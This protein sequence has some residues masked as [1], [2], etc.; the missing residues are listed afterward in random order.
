M[1]RKRRPKTKE[2]I[3]GETVETYCVDNV[4]F[5]LAYTD[6]GG[7]GL[8]SF[9]HL[10]EAHREGEK[11]KNVLVNLT[12]RGTVPFADLKDVEKVPDRDFKLAERAIMKVLPEDVADF[13]E[14]T[15][16]TPD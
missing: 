3:G 9:L 10:H 8:A 14:D 15:D 16:D 12:N 7:H 11:L 6:A 5:E 1:L 2:N 4:V 13:V